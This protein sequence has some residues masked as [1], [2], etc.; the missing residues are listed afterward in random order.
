MKSNFKK[1]SLKGLSEIKGGAVTRRIINSATVS[2]SN[3]LSLQSDIDI[4]H[5]I[6]V[7][8]ETEN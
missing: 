3:T 1:I 8:V 5:E 7:T 4:E 2:K 6:T